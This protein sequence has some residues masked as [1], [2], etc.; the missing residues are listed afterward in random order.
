MTVMAHLLH[1]LYPNIAYLYPYHVPASQC[2]NTGTPVCILVVSQ[3]YHV[4]SRYAH[5]FT[6]H[7][8]ELPHDRAYLFTCTHHS[9]ATQAHVNTCAMS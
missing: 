3:N 2:G 6:C 8:R 9:V 1:A 7:V 5:G 4:W